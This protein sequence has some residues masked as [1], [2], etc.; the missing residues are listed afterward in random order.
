MVMMMVGKLLEEDER[1]KHRD[2]LYLR[3]IIAHLGKS[4][5]FLI[6]STDL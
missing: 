1:R 2:L 4:K 6:N 3:K 5:L